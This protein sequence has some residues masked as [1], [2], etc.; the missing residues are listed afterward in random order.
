MYG[1]ADP[2]QADPDLFDDGSGAREHT[3]SA[4]RSVAS[5]LREC[6]ITLEGLGKTGYGGTPEGIRDHCLLT[7][8]QFGTWNDAAAFSGSAGK[9]SG[10]SFAELHQFFTDVLKGVIEAVEA[11]AGVHA[12]FDN[13]NEGEV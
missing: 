3:P 2:L 10:S 6:L 4:M 5:E 12:T 11:S 7:P 13:A 1:G 9:H 8:A